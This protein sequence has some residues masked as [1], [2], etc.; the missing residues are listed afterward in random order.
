MRGMKLK[1]KVAA[2]MPRAMIVSMVRLY[3][4]ICELFTYELVKRIARVE[5]NLTMDTTTAMIAIVTFL[6]IILPHLAGNAP[7]A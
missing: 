1:A 2:T 7:A 3:L 5:Y 4:I 6:G